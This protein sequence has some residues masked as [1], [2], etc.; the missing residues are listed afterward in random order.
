MRLFFCFV[1][2]LL[3]IHPGHAWNE[4][5]T[6]E[7]YATPALVEQSSTVTAGIE[8]QAGYEHMSFGSDKASSLSLLNLRPYVDW[9]NWELSLLLPLEQISNP[10]SFF[11]KGPASA[12]ALC[13]RIR[14]L[15]VS[16]ITDYLARGLISSSTLNYCSSHH[17]LAHAA[18]QPTPLLNALQL[19]SQTCKD[20]NNLS[21]GQLRRLERQG[22]LTTAI[23]KFCSI[24]QS[25]T[26]QN[27]VSLASGLGDVGLE[28]DRNIPS[29]FSWLDART[30]LIG[31]FDNASATQGLGSGAP[32]LSLQ[33]SAIAHAG[34]WVEPHLTV[35]YTWVGHNQQMYSN[36]PY[37]E[38][39][40]LFLPE[41]PLQPGMSYNYQ[42]ATPGSLSDSSFITA[43]VD[44]HMN[45]TFTLHAYMH[46][47]LQTTSGEPSRD[48]GLWLDALW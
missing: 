18:A 30:S 25:F 11:Q 44:W 9:G 41:K 42:P 24:P 23:A 21:L 38:A 26:S 3:L 46:H 15:S 17:L 5:D 39:D 16:T 27:E 32:T 45:R 8:M 33:S 10:N 43:F 4:D 36:F 22:T 6:L 34:F 40:L 35:G 19:T 28:L 13:T 37:A 1:W 48:I 12:R 20:I 47:Y 7:L 2:L 31:T 14:D 29:L